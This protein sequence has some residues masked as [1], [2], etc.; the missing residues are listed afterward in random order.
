MKN[1]SALG[2]RPSIAIAALAIALLAGG[3]GDG[4]ARST[5]VGEAVPPDAAPT[6]EPASDE[7]DPFARDLGTLLAH[8]PSTDQGRRGLREALAGDEADPRLCLTALRRLES[9]RAPERVEIAERLAAA[10]CET[11][12]ERLLA[13]NAVAVLERAKT[14]RAEQALAR[15]GASAASELVRRR[16]A[17]LASAPSEEAG[18]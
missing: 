12:Q 10:P 13:V 16:V 14:P 8:D 1:H 6:T 18:R 17:A 15:L 9:V 5:P 3:C 11:E 2:L 7:P 4:P